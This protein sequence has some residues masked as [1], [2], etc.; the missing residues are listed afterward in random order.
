[1]RSILAAATL[2][3]ATP[4]PAQSLPKPVHDMV[5]A[6]ARSGDRVKIDAVVAIAKETNKGAEAEI[7][8]IVAHHAA[9]RAAQRQATLA[10]A[11]LF[12]NWKGRGQVGAS[13]STGNSDVRSLTVGLNLQREGVAWRHRLDA[14]FDITDNRKGSDQERILTGYQLD[15]KISERAYSWARLEYERNREAGIKRRFAESAGL[16]WRAIQGKAVRWDLEAGPALRQ[17]KFVYYDENSV[18]G[19]GASRFAWKFSRHTEFSSDTAIFFDSSATINTTAALTSRMFGAIGTR[20]SYN[21][22]WEED[23]P[24]GLRSLDT[25]TRITLVY[26]F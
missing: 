20:L 16:G 9:I 21:L 17:T 11:G 6:A 13:L 25:T 19:R 5:E 15:Y 14:A 8:A 2:L 22:A 24:N 4:A 26:D 3:A 23:P 18:A 10:E 12:D 7:D 1:M